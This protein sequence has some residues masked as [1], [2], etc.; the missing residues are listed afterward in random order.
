MLIKPYFVFKKTRVRGLVKN[1]C[2]TYIIQ[3]LA[4]RF[5]P[6]RQFSCSVNDGMLLQDT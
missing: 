1:S 3:G 2:K 6:R 5:V 4:N